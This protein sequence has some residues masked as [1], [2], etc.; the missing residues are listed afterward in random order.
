MLSW[1]APLSLLIAAIALPF[2][3]GPLSQEYEVFYPV[4]LF[5]FATVLANPPTFL[6][7]GALIREGSY[8]MYAGHIAFILTFGLMGLPLIVL[9]SLLVEIGLRPRTISKR[10]NLLL[11]GDRSVE[12]LRQELPNPTGKRLFL[13]RIP[14]SAVKRFPPTLPCCLVSRGFRSQS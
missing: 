10:L 14:Q 5:G 11:K 4:G 6:R 7:Y 3:L 8:A 9:S 1:L 13:T 2:S 12:R